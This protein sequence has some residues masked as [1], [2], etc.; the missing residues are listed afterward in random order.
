METQCATQQPTAIIGIKLIELNGLQLM[1]LQAYLANERISYALQD[2]GTA[3]CAV[4]AAPTACV[5]HMAHIPKVTARPVTRVVGSAPKK[6]PSVLTVGSTPHKVSATVTTQPLKRPSF[7]KRVKRPSR[8]LT[9]EQFVQQDAARTD[10][11]P[12]YEK[13]TFAPNATFN[14]AEVVRRFKLIFPALGVNL[15]TPA[16]RAGLGPNALHNFKAPGGPTVQARAVAGILRTF[17]EYNGYLQMHGWQMLTGSREEFEFHF[18]EY[19]KSLPKA[20]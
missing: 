1:R 18:D 14:R 13:I 3:D 8:Y 11:N 4:A 5:D 2:V 12:G 19:L 17:R 20:E 7:K 15:T 16:K 9:M 6:A 10:S